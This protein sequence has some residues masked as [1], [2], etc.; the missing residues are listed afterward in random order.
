MTA[1]KSGVAINPGGLFSSSTVTQFSLPSA[2]R[3]NQTLQSVSGSVSSGSFELDAF[4]AL[5]STQQI[6]IDFSKF[7]KHT[8][9]D[10]AESK[11]NVAFDTIINYFPFD[12]L[13]EDI[14]KF[15]NGL[16]GYE[17]YVFDELWPKYIGYLHF[18]GTQPGEDPQGGYSA[19]L[20]TYISVVD[21]AGYLYPS[22]S[23][24]KDNQPIID[25][26]SSP[27]TCTFHVSL[28][29]QQSHNQVIMQKLQDNHGFSIFLS[30]SLTPHTTTN[31][32]FAISSGST[33]LTASVD[34]TKNTGSFNHCACVFSRNND[35]LS[36]LKIF[37][38]GVLVATSS[39]TANIG[40]LNFK[41]ANLNI[42]SGSDHYLG[43]YEETF[44][45]TTTLS[46]SIDDIRLYSTE[47]NQIQI[48]QIASG[49][50]GHDNSLLAFYKFNEATGSYV[51]NSVVLD[52]SGNSLHAQV[53]NFDSALRVKEISSPVVNEDPYRNPT[54]FPAQ[55]FLTSLNTRLLNSASL[56]D[57]NNPNLITKLVPRHYLEE[58]ADILG[59]PNAKA[60]LGEEYSYTTN[61]PGGGD[62][63]SPQL[64][65]SLLFMWAKFFDEI[66]LF[67]DHF[68]SLL[69]IDY[70]DSSTVA[71]LMLP[72][73]AK[74][75]GISLPN[76]FSG[77]TVEQ[78]LRGQNVNVDA[79]SSN[80]ALAK[81]QAQ[82][83]RRI[84]INIQDAIRSKGTIHGIKTILRA[85]GLDPDSMFRFR[86]F[87]GPKTLTVDNARLKLKQTSAVL[88]MNQ[89][90]GLSSPFLSGS[91]VEPGAPEIKGQF[92]N[93]TEE[94]P[95]G[96]SDDRWDGLFTS[97]SW[98]VEFLTEPLL[99]SQ[100]VTMSLGRVFATGSLG[101][102]M[103]ANCVA[104]GTSEYNIKTGSLS[105][106]HR[107][108]QTEPEIELVLTGAD[109]F[110][111]NLWHVAFGRKIMSNNTSSYFISAGR[112][113]EGV[114][115]SYF[116]NQVTASWSDDFYA[117]GSEEVNI[118][119]SFLEFGSGS[120]DTGITA[121]LNQLSN[122]HG[123][124]TNYSGSLSRIRFWSKSLTDDEISEHIRNFKSV[125]VENPLVNYNFKTT[126]SGSFERLR[127]DAQCDQEITSSDS[128]GEL[129]IF[130]Y[131]QNLFALSGS[132]FIP[133]KKVLNPHIFSYSSINPK[134]DERSSDNKIRVAGY[135]FDSNINEFNTLKAPVSSI[136]IGTPVEDDNR[137]AIEIS[138]AK[139][140]NEDI[141]LILGSLDILNDALGSPE[142]QFAD[143]YP[144][145]QAL[146]DVYFDRLTGRVNYKNLLSFYKWVD[147]S[148]GFLI[149][150]MI[151]RNTNFLGMNFV[152][153][154]HMLE[155]TKL[156]YLQEDIY[157][158]EN[159]RRGLQTD[160]NL[161]Q[162]VGKFKRY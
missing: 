85:T 3:K 150:R 29:E 2:Q 14:E 142:L 10:S 93:Q 5:K 53:Q 123:L 161:Q 105:V 147:N 117:S 32:V 19:N 146:R 49:T 121:G 16:T 159:D 157:L 77:A 25:F 26:T 13:N 133:N 151:P 140:L 107:P 23:K 135:L 84:L 78:Y 91:R 39:Q 83:W 101:K 162:I 114:I 35:E 100:I 50:Y 4:G 43:T 79:G 113:N 70:D 132:G 154:S 52:S 108:S 51:N 106:F 149:A 6:P 99:Q 103:F 102:T 33:A 31:L 22:I 141:V 110:D 86:E 64:I 58:E 36:R 1:R 15:L 120:I 62:I 9:F 88:Q 40:T 96:I 46:A 60:G 128:G 82:I 61:I 38:D 48:Q 156:R 28:P 98:S 80:V 139:A 44:E 136:P 94:N 24:R 59:Y 109:I 89:T 7:E 90:S 111:G 160:L 155:R 55:P 118:S 45:P 122:A 137:F 145:L 47:K 119:G 87:G 42:G 30:Q 18:S 153:E 158:G 116:Y 63:G 126:R 92:V 81:I 65:A 76:M 124:T 37:R 104:V 8:F 72:F 56:Y 41:A 71:D 144:D 66:K 17:R 11:V 97:G 127:I 57:A 138:T 20:G 68:G 130:D 21:Q 148:I 75:Y 54:L 34:L 125:G 129:S 131:S 134:F 115:E 73:F 143:N 95:N 67:V 112:Q 152:I 12:G 74:Y 27:F 69:K